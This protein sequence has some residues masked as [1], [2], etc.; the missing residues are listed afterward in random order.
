MIIENQFTK[1]T[2][3]MVNSPKWTLQ[4]WKSTMDDQLKSWVMYIPG[5]VCSP[6]ICHMLILSLTVFGCLEQTRRCS[7]AQI[8]QRYVQYLHFAFYDFLE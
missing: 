6:T 1:M 2:D 8:L 5:M 4:L 7:I 3:L